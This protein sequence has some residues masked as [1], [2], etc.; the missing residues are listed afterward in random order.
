MLIFRN[1]TSGKCFVYVEDNEDSKA[2]LILP[3]GEAKSLKLDLFEHPEEGEG[4]NFLARGLITS[5]QNRRY[6]QL[7]DTLDLSE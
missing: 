7:L 2:L 1:K 4:E 3:Q 6:R 5:E